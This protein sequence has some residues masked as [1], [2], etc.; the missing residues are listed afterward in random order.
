MDQRESD[1]TG[2]FRGGSAGLEDTA[3]AGGDDR[4]RTSADGGPGATPAVGLPPDEED[5]VTEGLAATSEI[6]DRDAQ[7]RAERRG[8]GTPRPD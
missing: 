4:A 1:P 8:D 7:D 3:D 2:A 6:A 5:R